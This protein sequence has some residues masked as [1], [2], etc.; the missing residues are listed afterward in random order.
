MLF[1]NEGRDHFSSSISHVLI[2]FTFGDD[3]LLEGD[4]FFLDLDPLCT[5]DSDPE[6][7]QTGDEIGGG[8]SAPRP[9]ALL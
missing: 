5:L 4:A 2:T 1:Y 7:R 3:P 6:L 9:S 8:I